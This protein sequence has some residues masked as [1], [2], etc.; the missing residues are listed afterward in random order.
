MNKTV[1]AILFDD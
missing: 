1:I